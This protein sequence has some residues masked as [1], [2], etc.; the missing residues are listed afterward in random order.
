MVCK[1]IFI[2]VLNLILAIISYSFTNLFN[3][4]ELLNTVFTSAVV[5]IITIVLLSLYSTDLNATNPN[6]L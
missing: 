6:L 4:F 1:K 3:M 5:I 2:T